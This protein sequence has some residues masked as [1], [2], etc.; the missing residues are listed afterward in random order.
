[1]ER[2]LKLAGQ[3]ADAAA[4]HA[5]RHDVEGSFVIE[6][7]EAARES[8]YLA[9]PVPG[10]LG[11]DGASTADIVEAQRIIGQACG[12]T[13]LACSM[14][15]HVAL[16]AAWRWRHGDDVVE[17]T[18]R[19][20]AEDRVVIVSTGGNDWT[21]PTTVATP[22]EGGWRVS[23]RKTFA[24]DSPSGQAMAT[25]AVVGEPAAGAEVLAF[26]CP[27]TAEGVTVEET[28]D[29]IGM[30]GTGSHDIVLD[31]VFVSEGQIT[32]RRRW[33]ELDRPLMLASLH[34]WPV[35]YAGYVGVAEAL[36]ETV[37]ATGKARDEHA[38]SI[39]LLDTY[40]QSARWALGGALTDLGD[41]PEPTMEHFVTLQQMKWLITMACRQIASLAPELAGG[42]AYARR[43]PVDRMIRDLGAATYH[44]YP[45]EKA[46]TLVGH[47]TLG[48]DP[49]IP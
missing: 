27:M 8:G 21:H 24:S 42:V 30:R 43:G 33:G 37:L 10:E 40:L 12:S 36:L 46:L 16:A 41:D 20:V 2:I 32:G 1:M 34:A 47:A 38:R 23:G 11:G 13:A 4:P 18:L 28:W 3:I 26:G 17:P 9:S 48:L 7:I 44:P 49:P 19:R 45:P 35:V 39:G 14:H 25:F 29:S 31:D 5:D 22:V 6:G 15:L